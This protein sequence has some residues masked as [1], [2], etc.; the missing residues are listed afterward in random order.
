MTLVNPEDFV[1]RELELGTRFDSKPRAE[2]SLAG[3][4]STEGVPLVGPVLTLPGVFALANPPFEPGLSAL[5]V[6]IA[7]CLPTTPPVLAPRL[8]D[9][10]DLL[11]AGLV[12][13][14]ANTALR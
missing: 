10:S 8:L 14:L 9:F 12:E 7:N 11:A 5:A 6:D 4:L 2:V 13:G 1:V 3:F